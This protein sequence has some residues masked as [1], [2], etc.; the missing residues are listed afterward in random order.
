MSLRLNSSGGGSV[1]LQE[2]VTASTRTLNLP[3]VDGTVITTADSGTVTPTMLSTGAPSWTSGGNL[4]FNSG[5]GSTAVAYGCRAWVN[6]NGTGTVAVR[7]SGNVSSLTDN[8]T[9]D[10]TV[11]FTTA[12]PDT[13]FSPTVAISLSA[14]SLNANPGASGWEAINPTTSSCRIGIGFGAT[15][16]NDVEVVNVHIHR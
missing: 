2:P 10:Y 3:N 8:G 13:N 6:F 11:N 9:G 7:A 12:M 15:G 4:S 16:R 14:S 1:T 5:Y